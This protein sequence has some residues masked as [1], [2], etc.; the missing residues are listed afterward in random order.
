MVQ[1]QVK[2][3][4][5]LNHTSTISCPEI[6]FSSIVGYTSKASER[7]FDLWVEGLELPYLFFFFFDDCESC[8]LCDSKYA[9]IVLAKESTARI[10]AQ[11]TT[12]VNLKLIPLD[13]NSFISPLS[14]ALKTG[15]AASKK[16]FS[17]GTVATE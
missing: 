4:A 2:R 9:W 13:P 10:I 11:S 6:S 3:H 17:W 15:P 12:S 8:W 1:I 5:S 7:Q 14:T 16:G